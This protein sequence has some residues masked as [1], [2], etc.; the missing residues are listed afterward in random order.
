MSTTQPPAGRA[1]G[2]GAVAS[3][4]QRHPGLA[5]AAITTAGRDLLDKATPAHPHH[6]SPARRTRACLTPQ[7]QSTTAASPAAATD[8]MTTRSAA[9]GRPQI[10]ARLPVSDWQIRWR[11]QPDGRTVLEVTDQAGNLTGLAAST[12]LPIVS[13][14]GAWRGTRRSA[15]G[16]RQQWALAIGHAST[17]DG[18]LTVTFT[19][20]ARRTTIHPATVDGLWV[21]A[22]TG[23]HAAASCHTPAAASALQLMPVTTRHR[24]AELSAPTPAHSRNRN[25]VPRHL[26]H[27]PGATRATAGCQGRVADHQAGLCSGLGRGAP[28][29]KTAGSTGRSRA[30]PVSSPTARTR[31][32]TTQ[33]RSPQRQTAAP[34]SPPPVTESSCTAC[35]W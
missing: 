25:P 28:R 23:H 3:P 1:P 19:Y 10:S 15:D 7:Q 8:P 21:A 17:L 12:R 31:A 14:D 5:L 18:P 2:G 35:R 20:R 30:A 24:H 33:D 34:T 4:V 9:A 22:I 11:R 26:L 16:S 13:V 27:M 6:R 32:A 29:S